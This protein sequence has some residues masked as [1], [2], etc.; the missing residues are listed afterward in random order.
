M[1]VIIILWVIV[2]G[3]TPDAGRAIAHIEYE[4]TLAQCEG[5]AKKIRNSE[6]NRATNVFAVCTTGGV[7]K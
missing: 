3:H 2:S 4:G 1:K 7:E 6:Y 5:A